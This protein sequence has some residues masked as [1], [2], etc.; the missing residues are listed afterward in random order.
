M[1]AEKSN[2]I[3]RVSRVSRASRVGITM[4]VINF[5][6]LGVFQELMGLEEFKDFL[7]MAQQE[8][9]RSRGRMSAHF[10]A[11][12][13]DSFRMAVHRLK[14]AL[15]TAGCDTLFTFLDQLEYR[16]LLEPLFVPT[17]ETMS[18]FDSLAERT[19]QGLARVLDDGLG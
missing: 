18:E 15:G 11:E 19:S 4:T 13:W 8:L 3:A 7:H 17:H 16:M 5:E 6:I 12:E 2:F 14:G 1:V 9:S 10:A